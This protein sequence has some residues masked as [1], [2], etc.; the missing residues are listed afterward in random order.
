MNQPPP[1]PGNRPHRHAPHG[2]AAPHAC[3]AFRSFRGPGPDRCVVIADTPHDAAG[4]HAAEVAC[5]GVA[6]HHV[7]SAQLTEAKADRAIDSLEGGLPNEALEQDLLE[8]CSRGGLSQ[9]SPP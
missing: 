7:N 4:A 8:R 2:T 9:E 1:H 5:V 3:G 6:S